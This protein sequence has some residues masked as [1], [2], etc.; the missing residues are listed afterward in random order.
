MGFAL[1]LSKLK[2]VSR[3]LMFFINIVYKYVNKFVLI[4]KLTVFS[5]LEKKILVFHKKI[6]C[7]FEKNDVF[8]QLK[9][10]SHA[11]NVEC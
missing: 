10:G 1:H 7:G 11:S 9:N 6:T 2:L 5:Q 8:V 4:S 3:A